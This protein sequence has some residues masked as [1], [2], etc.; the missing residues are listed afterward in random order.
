MSL[1]SH[2]IQCFSN[3]CPKTTGYFSAEFGKMFPMDIILL[4]RKFIGNLY[5]IIMIV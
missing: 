2:F 5:P 4:G 1:K 3:S